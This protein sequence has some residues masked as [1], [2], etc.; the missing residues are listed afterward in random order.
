MVIGSEAAAVRRSIRR[1]S[2]PSSPPSRVWFLLWRTRLGYEIR[3]VGANPEAAVYAGI[4]LDRIIIIAM[5]I[6]GGLAG[7]LAVNEVMGVQHRL[8][9][10]VCR[11][12]GFR[13]H[14]RVAHGAIAS[15]GRGAGSAA[16]RPSLSGRRRALLPEADHHRAT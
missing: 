12:R 16:V 10:G 13:R 8:V 7:L 3:T 11:R 2:S 6:S 5:L 4:K 15:R 9:L 14:R 1:C